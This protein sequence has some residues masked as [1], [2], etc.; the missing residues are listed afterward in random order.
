MREREGE[1]ER[2]REDRERDIQREWERKKYIERER[3][4]ERERKRW[5][6]CTSAFFY[7]WNARGWDCKIVKKAFLNRHPFFPFLY[8]IT[9][10][11]K[12]SPLL[13]ISAAPFF[14][15]VILKWKLNF[16]SEIFLSITYNLLKKIIQ[17]YF[18]ESQ[19]HRSLISLV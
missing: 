16:V 2:E 12:K 15:S 10:T 11:R 8:L 3:G 5:L 13:Q 6:W 18:T 4:K 7:A 19:F 14:C 1:G 9:G 17:T